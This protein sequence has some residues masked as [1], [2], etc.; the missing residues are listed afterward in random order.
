MRF[1][2][3]CA[4]MAA[5]MAAGSL[6][7]LDISGYYSQRNRERP[8]RKRTELIILHTTEGGEKGS[9]GKLLANG[10]AH[11]MVGLNGHVYNIVERGCLAYHAG[12]S[13]WNGRTDVDKFSVGIEIVGY[14]HSD[15]TPAQ[16]RAIK[17]LIT[18]LQRIYRIP[19][20]KV[21]CHSMV[22]YGEPNQWHRRPHR[23]R[24]RCGMQ[25]AKETVRA[26]LG[27]DRKPSY[28]PDV[29]SGRLTIGD[30]YLAK[31]LYGTVRE[32]TEAVATFTSPSSNIITKNRSAW[33]IAGDDYNSAK[34]LYV[35]P[36][37]TRKRGNKIKDWGR[38][39]VGTKVILG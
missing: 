8:Y 37:G 20:D 2:T 6:F 10:E 24:K 14:H 31:I 9:L 18:N 38:I 21:L 12:T 29:R 28:D 34:T 3:I 23:G 39:P 30:P 19:D 11:Y 7:A 5:V 22:A 33:D 35:Y 26:K 1:R 15:L 13:M 32:Q 25:F 27:L 17:E 16:Y 4:V 36:D